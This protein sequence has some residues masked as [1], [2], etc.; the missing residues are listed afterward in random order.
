MKE[1]SKYLGY[2]QVLANEHGLDPHFVD[3]IIHIESAWNPWAVR[4]EQ[5][6][7]YF[8][9]A[10][11]HARQLGI[12]LQTELNCQKMSFGLGQVMGGTARSGGYSDHLTKLLIPERNIEVVC[13][14]LSKNQKRYVSL[15]DQASAYNS[16]FADKISP[17]YYRNQEY[18]DKFRARYKALSSEWA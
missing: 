14:I 10:S 17:S 15:D 4:Y 13:Q 1:R 18:V 11:E 3:T 6:W 5:N 12:S 2:M 7:K 16:G 9:K 8:E